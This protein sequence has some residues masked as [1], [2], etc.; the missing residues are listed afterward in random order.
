MKT[1]SL[2]DTVVTIAACAQIAVAIFTGVMAR[3]TH[4]LAT[5]TH[6]MVVEARRQA[7]A[8]EAAVAQSIRPWLTIGE[9]ETEGWEGK[10]PVS[11]FKDLPAM[12]EAGPP[13]SMRS[14]ASGMW[15]RV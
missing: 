4:G 15:V 6:D 9:G 5:E 13:V 12:S 14:C 3:R 10:G 7:D 1:W 2:A 8:T 11:N